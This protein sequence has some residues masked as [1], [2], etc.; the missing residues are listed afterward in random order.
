[1]KKTL[2]KIIKRITQILILASII[3]LIDCIVAVLANDDSIWLGDSVLVVASII[4]GPVVGGFATF[5]S[6]IVIDYLMYNNLDFSFVAMLESL[7]MILIGVIYRRLIKD[8]DKFGIKEIVVFNFVQVLV[9][10][11]VLYLA[12]PPVAVLFFGFIFNDWGKKAIVS[13]MAALADNAFSA[14]ISTALI[15]TV[16]LAICIAIRK[17]LKETDNIFDCIRSLLKPNFISKEYRPRAMEYSIGIVFA[18]AL[19]MVDGIVS[20]H[21]LGIDALAATSIMFPLISLSTFMSKLIT[22]GCSNLCARANGDGN[23]D[24]ASKLFTLGFLIVISLGLLETILFYL[25]QNFYFDY[26]NTTNSIETFARQYYKLYIFAPPFM[27]LA[28]FCDEIISSDGDDILSYTGYLLS[29]VV[30]VG[31]SIILSAK[32]GMSGLALATVVSY[33]CY[34]VVVSLHFL[35]KSNTYKFRLYFSFFDILRFAEHSFKSNISGLCMFAASTAFTK[36]ILLLWG[37]DYLIA[38][39]VLCAMLEVYEMVNGPSE[40]AE[41]LMATY[42]GEKNAEGIKILFN[43]AL[44]ACLLG[45]VFVSLLLLLMPNTILLLY[46]IEETP[47]RSE[48]IQCIRFCSVGIIAASVGGF[49]SDYYGDIGKPLWSCLLIIFRTALFPILFCST[50]C[51]NSGIV[52]MGKGMLLSQVSAIAIFY[53]FVFIVKGGEDIPYMLDDKD[54]E[55]VKMKSFEFKPS[56]YKSLILWIDESLTSYEVDKIK[57]EEAEKIVLSLCD[58]TEKK[59]EKNKVYGECVL[60]F[61]DE[62]EIIIKDNGVLFKPD[63]KDACYSYNVLMSCNRSKISLTI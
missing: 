11:A 32:I 40:A 14:C 47:L 31:L 8:E 37:S 35:K 23:Y 7:S 1:M 56:E 48:L 24:R 36:T 33:I 63:I 53:S 54:F 49:L 61:I 13:D 4:Y 19:T 27:A 16:L 10:T 22:T 55:K 20:G 38:N 51:L 42:A 60:R 62:P 15:G 34:L 59:C 45:G 25:M 6:S 44:M 26:F 18:V 41:Y 2:K 17:K 21:L 28:T 9:N 30:N 43:E 58:M 57:I 50:F 46:G 29:F 5:I 3:I 52:A 39:T 12:S